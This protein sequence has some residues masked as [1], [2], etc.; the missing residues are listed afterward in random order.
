MSTR[1]GPLEV[2]VWDRPFRVLNGALS[3]VCNTCEGQIAEKIVQHGLDERL[4]AAK[5][6]KPRDDKDPSKLRCS[7][8]TGTISETRN[9]HG[10]HVE[11]VMHTPNT[12][13]TAPHPSK[14]LETHGMRSL[15]IRRC[16]G[17]RGKRIPPTYP[18]T[19]LGM[20]QYAAGSRQATMDFLVRHSWR[21]G[22]HRDVVLLFLGG[23]SVNGSSLISRL[24]FM[25]VKYQDPAYCVTGKMLS[26]G[27]C[28][29][30]SGAHLIH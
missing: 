22:L 27:F 13:R 8:Q 29:E 10:L 18:W 19:V 7:A 6:V 1:H 21:K 24:G 20:Y 3:G 12:S 28:W 9:S 15:I 5:R 25:S 17:A 11:V 14:V 23:N 26:C 16:H 4:R 30:I 2:L